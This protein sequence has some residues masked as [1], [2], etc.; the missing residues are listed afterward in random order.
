MK[1]DT[2]T[3]DPAFPIMAMDILSNV[4]SRSD[5][6]RELGTYLTEEIRDLT[7][8][9]C[10][11]LIQCLCTVTVTAHRVVAVNPSRRCEWA[12]SP[13]VNRLYDVV[14]RMPA[15][16][17]W[18]G[19]EPSEVAGLLRREGFEL[20]MAF[21]LNA[22][23]FRVGAMLVLGLPDEEHISSV[24]DLLNNLSAI[25]ALVL[26]N[27]FLFERQEEI[28][29]ERTAE[30]RAGEEKYRTLIES[31]NDAVF[32]HE[33]T[34]NGM[35]GPFIVVNEL[36]C[37]QLG[38]SREELARM[39]PMDLDDPRYRDRIALAMER[40]LKDGH[41]VFETAQMAKD[42]RSIPVEVSTR[43][44]ELKGKRLL[45]SIVR[46]IT[47]RKRAEDE[48]R[49]LNEE[50]EQRVNERTAELEVKNVELKQEM[51]LRFGQQQFLEALLESIDAAIVACNA[52]GILTLF[53]RK[54]RELHGL[55]TPIPADQ[56]AKHY[57]LFLADG[58]TAMRKE[59]VPLF[60]ALQ[61]ERVVNDEMMIIPT[62]GESKTLLASG[63]P[64]L[65]KEGRKIGAVIAMHDITERKKFEQAL[66]KSEERMR[67]FFER[68][69]VGMAIT[70][71]QKG[72]LQVNDKLCRMLGY[73]REEL[74][75]MTWAQMTFPEDLTPDIAQFNRLLSG[76]IDDYILEKRFLR[77]DGS[78]VFTNLAVGCV[79]NA[80]QSVDY[81]LALLEDITERKR[82]EELIRT[83]NETLE[84]RVVERTAQL[85][86]A[87]ATLNAEI[88]ERKRM[89]M[90]LK[91]SEARYRSS[92]NLLTS[93]LESTANVSMYALDRKYRYLAFNP[94]HCEGA[95]RLWGADISVGMSMLDAIDSDEHREF[96][97]QGFDE[98]LEGR[99]CFVESKEVISRDGRQTVEY[100]DNYGSPIFN[101]DGEVV[102]L[103]VFAIDITERK[104][105]EEEIRRLQN[106]LANIID[107]MPSVLAGMDRNETVTQWNRQAEILSGISAM[108]AVGRPITE[109]L[110]DFSPWIET[111]RSEIDQ[112]RPAS[113][114]K[115]LIE[116]EGERRFYDLM[117][118][119]LISNGVEGAV[120]RIE[121]TTERARIQELMI[122]TEKMMSVGGLAAGMA[123]EINNPLGIIIQAIQ[124]IERRISPELPANRK[125]AEEL[126]VSL[127]GIKAYFDKRQIPEFVGSIREASLRAAR[128]IANMLRFS[129]YAGTTMQP[130][131]P[132]GI[133]D[134]AVE[135]AAND[136]DLKKKY[137]FRS[138]EIIRDYDSDMPEVPMVAVEIEQVM[139][140]LLKNAAQAMTLNLPNQRP[141]ISLRLRREERYALIEV[142]DNGPGMK[143]EVRRRAFEPF[144]TTKEPGMGT[145]LGL[146]V[147]YM[148]VTQNHKGLMEVV[149]KPGKG[150]CFRVRLP[151][152][153]E[154]IHE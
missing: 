31:A 125:A 59:D 25:V 32:I 56:W 37:R 40:I 144:F 33:I 139:L 66:Q 28:I 8:A 1:R 9:R 42:G 85:N 104:K 141:R 41:A 100:R 74:M 96:C 29:Q 137:D 52:D 34:E 92:S 62:M 3:N 11:L 13:A 12:E 140:N 132:A 89:E 143:E 129:R 116:K 70:S 133:I 19:D 22:G 81:V 61:G 30:L 21:P 153:K 27:S 115:L 101:D 72:W 86:E 17:F 10:V 55:P 146:S 91:E 44:L 107:S 79:R 84:E 77:K 142:E 93:I 49:I 108:A 36:A 149:S 23:A 6:P 2:I 103:T 102:G 73:S 105:A 106:Y 110:P 119:P 124:N 88:A 78:I 152:P 58:K 15:A 126:G 24:L 43:V 54:S 26:R 135:L 16:Q 121:D 95:K 76:E 117:V 64:I 128:I 99:G 109:V 136:Y 123:H 130:A 7:G 150:S 51:D 67:L 127:E 120:L 50:L 97:R 98:V 112:Q 65:D 147:S 69:L 111:M 48:I 145:G 53:N 71:P 4:L 154:S 134:Q 151:L 80:D 122:Q 47:E 38:Y 20:S 131:S 14:H 39:T 148:I 18:R 63:R 138:I 114:E 90:E 68:Q 82:A 94:R 118:Y 57:D 46:D 87:I 45:F 113:M 5:D 60:R 83:L 35:P 75:H